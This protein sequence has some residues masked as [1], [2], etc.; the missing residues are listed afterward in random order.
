MPAG[1]FGHFAQMDSLK[2]IHSANHE[3]R[4]NTFTVKVYA[5]FKNSASCEICY[6]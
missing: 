6:L 4:L 1:L 5:I 3:V 2:D